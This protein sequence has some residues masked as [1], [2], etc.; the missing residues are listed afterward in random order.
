M[1]IDDDESC[2]FVFPLFPVYILPVQLRKLLSGNPSTKRIS[3]D[4]LFLRWR[5]SHMPQHRTVVEYV[6]LYSTVQAKKKNKR[7]FFF[8]FK[9]KTKKKVS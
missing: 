7:I 1:L 3:R 6:L 9:K 8:L 4:L 2:Y 5:E